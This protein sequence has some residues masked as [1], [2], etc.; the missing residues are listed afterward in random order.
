MN[1]KAKFDPYEVTQFIED[2]RNGDEMTR[3]YAAEDLG[4]GKHKEGIAPLVGGLTDPSIAVAESCADA[5]VKIGGEEVVELVA[6]NLASEDV[7]LRN[8]SVEILSLLGEIALPILKEKLKSDDRDVRKFAVD[9]L[10][11]IGSEKSMEALVRALDDPDVNISSTAADGLGEIGNEKHLPVLGKYLDTDIWMKCAV[12][13]SIGSIGGKKAFDIVFPMIQDEDLMVKI[14]A[15]QAM[16]RIGDP[17]ALEILLAILDKDNLAFLGSEIINAIHEIVKKNQ[18]YDF[19]NLI[20]DERLQPIYFVGTAFSTELRIKAISILGNFLSQDSLP[21][22]YGQLGCDDETIRDAAIDAIEQIHP[23]DMKDIREI[24]DDAS[25]SFEQ[26]ISAIRVLGRLGGEENLS[27][28]TRFL[29]SEDDI[30][31]CAALNELEGTMKDV[32]VDQIIA[33]LDSKEPMVRKS[34]AQAM[35]RLEREEFVE[36]LIQKIKDEDP[37]VHDAVD[38]AL[39]HIGS[40]KGN[41]RIKP[42]L[43]SFSPAE[44]LMAFEYFGVHHPEEISQKFFDALQDPNPDIR[45]IALKVMGNLALLD[46][47]HI[48]LGLN[49]PV[50]E[51]QVQAVRAL[52][53]LKKDEKL[54]E[55][56]TQVLPVVSDPREREK[57][58]LIQILS[59][60]DGF[61]ALSCVLPFLKD[62]S[63]WVKL[64]TVEAL[65]KIGDK[66]AIPELK[67]LLDSEDREL[68]EAVEL[69]IEELEF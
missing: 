64:E 59:G 22:L 4:Y 2:L 45:V 1:D 60:L 5:L 26:K 19:F 41:K 52:N 34:A 39:I 30:L 69:A 17:K 16:A 48:R 13:R 9:T 67:N 49:D 62:V 29:K 68:V 31:C 23:E 35:E 57:V 63:S 65:R 54:F 44:R 3:R 11:G 47:D 51:V 38:Q 40:E 14:T 24:L 43:E 25:T 55:F 15:V 8:H 56:I 53:S 6:P 58:E 33:L 36:A 12:I 50:A 20:D 61:N 32:P 46:F 37:E 27:L 7:R 10:V 42:Y 21:F 66:K 18:D 28:V